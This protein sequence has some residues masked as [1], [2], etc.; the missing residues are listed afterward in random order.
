MNGFPSLIGTSITLLFTGCASVPVEVP[1][2]TLPEATTVADWAGPERSPSA[3]I[4]VERPDADWWQLFDDEQL[5]E[6]IATGLAA[7]Q[8]IDIAEA[9]MRQ[10][11]A[12]I[13]AA[14]AGSRPQI[15]A[16]AEGARVKISSQGAGVGSQLNNAGL[17]P[18]R[19]NS[20][21]L[22]FDVSWEV[23]AWGRIG[24]LT[25][26]ASA[27]L[28][29]AEAARQGMALGITAAIA[30]TYLDL[31]ARQ[32]TLQVER[33]NVSISEQQ[34]EI[35]EGR[36]LGGLSPELDVVRARGQLEA[37]RARLP[38][39]EAQIAA[40]SFAL[41][42]LTGRLPE[43]LRSA[44]AEPRELATPPDVLPIGIRS[45]VLTR[46]PDVVAA[47]WQ[48]AAAASRLE[49]SVKTRFPQLILSSAGGT[50][51]QDFARLLDAGSL[52]WLIGAAVT[53]PLYQGGRIRAG[54]EDTEASLEIAALEYDQTALRALQEAESALV[55]FAEAQRER[56]RLILARAA[57]EE[58]AGIALKLF[59]TGLG[60]YLTV[61]E[62]QRDDRAV[63]IAL[64]AAR[65]RVSQRAV[66]L[67]R[68]IGGGWD[69]PAPP[70]EHAGV[71]YA[72]SARRR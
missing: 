45:E 16:R 51:A 43:T 48:V 71:S 8:E 72:R 29:A 60:D 23:D 39:L 67:Y 50:D 27:D 3:A 9:R 38:G 5:S 4:S 49:A 24:A 47:S 20:F 40:D 57:T 52:T 68:A 31:R 30:A 61:L 36:V 58:A 37:A 69:A 59:D 44:L 34:L 56:D 6:L 17:I 14:R 32:A 2:S 42:V 21:N 19:F 26:A 25:D 33:S 28:G 22:G 1:P 18:N 55:A 15:G 64:V 46:R 63:A 7:N 12:A 13:R 41:G 10:A 62:A 70:A 53:A 54:I 65:A 35:A 66:D 11:A